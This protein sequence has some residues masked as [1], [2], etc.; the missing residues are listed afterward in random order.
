[1]N[2]FH[3]ISKRKRVYENAHKVNEDVTLEPLISQ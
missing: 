3:I 1:M 2:K